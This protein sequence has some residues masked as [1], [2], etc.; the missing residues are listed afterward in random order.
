[1]VKL[2]KYTTA[3]IIATFVFMLKKKTILVAPLHWG[4]GHATRCIPIIRALL[5]HGFD[6]LLASDRAALL[7]LQKEFPQLESLELPSYNI[8]YP[9][10]GSYFKW[11]MLLK[12]PHIQRTISA[13][14]RIVKHLVAEG[15]I[16]GIISDNRLGVRNSKIPSVFITHQLNVLTGSTSY[17]SSKM[18]QKIIKKFDACWV[19]DTDDVLMNLSGKLGHL[20]VEPFPIKYIGVLSRMEKKEVPKTIDILVLLSG[21]EPQRTI[22]EEKLKEKLKKSEKKIVMVRGIVEKEQ[23]WENFEKIKTVNFMMS[24]ELEETLN[25]SEIVISRSGYTTIMD[26]AVLEKKAFFI[27]TPGQYEQEYLAKRLKDLGIVPFCRQ[28]KFKLKKLNKIVTYKG[29]KALTQ[30]PVNFTDLF[31]L[32]EGE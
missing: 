32:F 26:L 24:N 5:D 23:N 25:K 2:R 4:L 3:A 20:K 15:K 18:H 29:L 22:F 13:E 10:K 28:D 14:K 17:F 8:T 21:P 27:P 1:M 6:V 7:L 12:L 30:Q 19:P 16:Q 9:K 11:K 31:S